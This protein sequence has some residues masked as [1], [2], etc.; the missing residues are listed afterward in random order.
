LEDLSGDISFI[1]EIVKVFEQDGARLVAEME[2]AYEQE[3]F[4]ALRESAHALKGTAANLGATRLFDLSKRVN[5]LKMSQ[6]VE[7][8]APL[9]SEVK[10]EFERVKFELNYYVRQRS[11]VAQVQ[12]DSAD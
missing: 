12:H 11:A 4:Q 3:Q 9:V 8:S 6:Y 5:E 2:R 7:L 10:E 1:G